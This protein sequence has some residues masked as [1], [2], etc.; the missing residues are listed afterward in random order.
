[1]HTFFSACRQHD[2]HSHDLVTHGQG[3][4]LLVLGTFFWVNRVVRT[5]MNFVEGKGMLTN[6]PN[7]NLQFSLY[8]SNLLV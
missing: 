8:I 6:Y 1:M 7:H 4:V 2:H 5:P 3:H